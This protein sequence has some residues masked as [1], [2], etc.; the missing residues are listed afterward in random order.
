ML[1][2]VIRNNLD[3]CCSTRT[4]LFLYKFSVWSLWADHETI[5]TW[6]A[7]YKMETLQD[8]PFARK[9]WLLSVG[10]MAHKPLEVII[11]LWNN[12]PWKLLEFCDCK[13]SE[14]ENCWVGHQGMLFFCSVSEDKQTM[15][16]FWTG[17]C[18]GV[19]LQCR[20]YQF[21]LAPLIILNAMMK[22]NLRYW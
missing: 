15:V 2:T 8:V 16:I 17:Q 19:S 18:K 5:I 6:I 12:I 11:W 3:H 20:Y 10:F 9:M 4:V 21:L 14:R 22:N 13:A 1:C 7:G